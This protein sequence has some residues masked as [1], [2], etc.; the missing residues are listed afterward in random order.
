[1][2]LAIKR[3]LPSFRL[4]MTISG[5]SAFCSSAVNTRSRNGAGAASGAVFMVS[6]F[7]VVLLLDGLLHASNVMATAAAKSKWCFMMLFMLWLKI[8][9]NQIQNLKVKIQK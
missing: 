3:L 6:V 5:V 2:L 1:M 4:V 9:Y 7:A 8:K